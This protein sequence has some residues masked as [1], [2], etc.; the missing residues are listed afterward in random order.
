MLENI[1]IQADVRSSAEMR[2]AVIDVCLRGIFTTM[3]FIAPIM[4]AQGSG[5]V[6]NT[7]SAGG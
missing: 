6:I 4:K 1:A 5:K 2:D 3:R 7:S